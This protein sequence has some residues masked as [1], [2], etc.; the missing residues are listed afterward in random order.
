MMHLSSKC[1]VPRTQSSSALLIDLWQFW[2]VGTPTVS[3][4]HWAH[5]PLPTSWLWTGT[6]SSPAWSRP[7][8]W[9][10][11]APRGPCLWT[12]T[13][14]PSPAGGSAPRADRCPTSRLAWPP[15]GEK[16]SRL[17]QWV[18]AIKRHPSNLRRVAT[19][20]SSPLS[21]LLSHQYGRRWIDEQ[22]N[23]NLPSHDREQQRLRARVSAARSP[24]STVVTVCKAI[25]LLM[26]EWLM[27]N[28][29]AIV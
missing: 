4:R 14:S 28:M 6:R 3:L 24:Q 25:L 13:T 11:I 21:D 29:H 12:R 1:K 26:P 8:S 15:A 2:P 20:S 7:K 16:M 5:R 10:S 27:K 18:T 23:R 22:L 9:A 19:R 17:S